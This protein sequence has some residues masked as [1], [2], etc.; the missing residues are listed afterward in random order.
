MTEANGPA[1]Y[2]CGRMMA[3]LKEP[4]SETDKAFAA[5]R[6]D[7]M[8][9]KSPKYKHC[10]F[11][12]LSFKEAHIDNGE[13]LDCT[14][15]GCYFRR[16]HISN[17][18]F[19]GCRFFDCNFNHVALQ[20][21]RFRFSTFRGCQISFSEMEYSLPTEPNLREELA[22]NLS[23]ESSHLG[24]AKESR[25]Y[26]IAEIHAHEEHLKAAIWCEAKWYQ[27]HFDGFARLRALLEWLLS[28]LNRW[29]WGYGERSAVLIRNLLILA[30]LVFPLLFIIF[31]DQLAHESGRAVSLRDTLYFSLHNIIPA[32]IILK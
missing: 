3:S 10:T 25:R 18:N 23:V 5:E 9:I 7:E 22:R 27:D 30:F 8:V 11:A 17:C 14:F 2:L 29:L 32:G 15:I 24:L 1:V 19:V 6:H 4:Y 31:I 13:F 21:C 16:A 26:R 20:S 12:N 28:L